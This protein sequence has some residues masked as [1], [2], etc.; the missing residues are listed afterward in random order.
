MVA[1][2]QR[3]AAAE[4]VGDKATFLKADLFQTDLSQATVIT[5]FLLPQINLDLRPK[6]LDLKP[7]TRIV[8]NTFTMGE[9]QED[10]KTTVTE[11]C[12]AWCTAFLWIIP[13]KVQGSWRSPQGELELAQ[14]FQMVSGTLRSGGNSTPITNG[15]LRGEQL[16]FTAGTAAFSGRVMAGAI[17]G[18][19]TSGANRT[20]WR[21]TR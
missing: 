19:V 21:A 12:G 2:S 8:S 17:E 16:T 4:N 1:L 7:G 15:R 3:N 14:S 6:L 11:D 9:W 13:A 5:M 18:T 10:E 20:E